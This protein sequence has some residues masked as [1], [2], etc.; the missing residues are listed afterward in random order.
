M[1]IPR[2]KPR[3]ILPQDCNKV[4][5]EDCEN[6][7]YEGKC[8][9]EP[10]RFYGTDKCVPNQDYILQKE[11]A[12]KGITGF[13]KIDENNIEEELQRRNEMCKSLPASTCRSEKAKMLG[14]QYKSGVFRK[15]RCQLADKIINYYYQKSQ[16]CMKKDCPRDREKGFSL[17]HE[18]RMEFNDMVEA[19]MEIYKK[20]NKGEDIEENYSR[21]IDIYNELLDN[22][23]VYL[24]EN[25]G[26]FNQ[27][28]T[29]YNEIRRLLGEDYC[30]CV[31]IKNCVGKGDVGDFCRNK[32]I[33]TK[34][35]LICKEHK[36]CFNDRKKKFD[37]FKNSFKKLCSVKSCK[38][39]LAELESFYNMIK[40]CTE[41]ETLTYKNALIDYLFI[42]RQYIKEIS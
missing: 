5:I 16:K 31:N 33:K 32:G 10:A 39:E 1:D 3:L 28:N 26:T 29:K 21:F 7:K 19:L 15:G 35:G 18:H 22:Y 37:A 17:C 20:I 30:Q 4:S 2:R 12:Q 34:T 9:I 11:L 38:Q 42:I 13:V 40:F 14:C 24:V 27:L 23:N 25:M 36:V 6:P 8:V 41:G